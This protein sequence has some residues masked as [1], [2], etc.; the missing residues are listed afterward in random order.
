LAELTVKNLI[1]KAYADRKISSY[2]PELQGK[3]KVI[4][5]DFLFTIINTVNPDFFP[6]NIKDLIEMKNQENAL[7]R[8]KFVN[9]KPE[10][11]QMI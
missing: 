7:K 3:K 11:L 8:Q 9:I 10:F 5:R 2:L 6:K 1:N 4:N